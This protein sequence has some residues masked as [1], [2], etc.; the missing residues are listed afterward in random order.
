MRPLQRLNLR[1][2]FS[3]QERGFDEHFTAAVGE[4]VYLASL[5]VEFAM[6]SENG[7]P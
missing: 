2:A 3:H 1:D 5:R 4:L 6:L 7:S